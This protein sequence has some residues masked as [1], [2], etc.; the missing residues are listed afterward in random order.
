MI[1]WFLNWVTRR[2]PDVNIRDNYLHRWW[3][4]PRNRFFNIYLHHIMGND[5]DQALHDH[6]W[7]NVSIPL[8]GRIME[9]R[10]GG[11]QQVMYPGKVVFRRGVTCH[12]LEIED[13]TDAWTLFITGPKYRE[14]GF[15]CPKGWVIWTDFVDPNDEGE[16]GAGCG[17]HT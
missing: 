10:P 17:E 6:P 8:R 9:F 12:R 15:H 2:P 13:G 7:Y 14:W 4:I 11:R 1:N 5:H 3:V 16:V